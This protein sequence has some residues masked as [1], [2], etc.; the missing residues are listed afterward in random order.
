MS[1]TGHVIAAA[2]KGLSVRY[3]TQRGNATA[4]PASE[5]NHID[6][7]KQASSSSLNA[8]PLASRNPGGKLPRMALPASSLEEAMP[9]LWVSRS[10]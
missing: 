6:L 4:T 5:K 1:S 7:P 3:L 9:I 8:L 10:L 2:I